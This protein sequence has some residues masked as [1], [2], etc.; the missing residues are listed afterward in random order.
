MPARWSRDPIFWSAL[1][2]GVVLRALPLLLWGWASDD[3]TR[4]ECIYKIV[5]RPILEGEGLG[6]APKGW[7]PAPGYPYVLAAMQA[8]FGSFESVKWL[9]VAMTAPI[10]WIAYQLGQRVGGLRGARFMAAGMAVHPTFVFFAGTMW[11]ETFYT[12][13]LTGSL[14]GLLWAREGDARR[15]IVPGVVLGVCVLF[16]GVATYLAPLFALALAAPEQVLA[17]LDTW[18]EALRRRARHAATF[19]V[20]IAVTVL[21]YSI[22]ASA[23]WGGA[24]VSDA[25]LGHVIAL[26]NDDFEP[27]TFDY[28][29][30]Q[31]TGRQYAK[32]LAS[33]RRDC[34]RNGG[35]I[36]H[37]RCEVER[38]TKWILDHPSEFVARVPTRMAQLFNP[39]SFLTR[40]VRWN[41]W[42]TLPWELKELIVLY[43]LAC[44]YLLVAFG[45]LTAFARG[46]GPWS[47]VAAGTIAYHVGIIGVLYGITRFRLPLEPLWMLYIAA[48][49]G[50]TDAPIRQLRQRPLALAGA[51]ILTSLLLAAMTRYA[52]T[53]FP[54]LGG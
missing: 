14:L 46:R 54:G 43:Q 27:V 53:G 22:H 25:T 26:G 34:P 21:P 30:G 41:Y 8:V 18:R 11:T 13:L 52:W 6:L 1:L 23:R 48:W 49:L 19:L 44:T 36:A 12:A 15:A 42:P 33:G 20:A 4:D 39:H 3:C 10:L 31:L 29:I 50:S 2:I 35:P 38:A 16:R 45:T 24:V 9:Q 40:H 37:D 28:M 17:P 51:V 7:L 47:L 5:A 32:T